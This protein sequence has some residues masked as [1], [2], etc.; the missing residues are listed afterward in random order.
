MVALRFHALGALTVLKMINLAVVSLFQVDVTRG[1]GAARTVTDRHIVL[2][3]GEKGRKGDTG[4]TACRRLRHETQHIHNTRRLD[5]Q[6]SH[7]SRHTRSSH[8]P[9]K[10]IHVYTQQHTESL[11]GLRRTTTSPLTA[12]TGL[13]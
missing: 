9:G 5:S 1:P 13:C 10:H 2:C 12:D 6:H 7:G 8:V 11:R 4:R 3:G